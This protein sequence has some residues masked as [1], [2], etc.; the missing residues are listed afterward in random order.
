MKLKHQPHAPSALH[1]G[2]KPWYTL[3][4]STVSPQNQPQWKH[5]SNPII[6]TFTEYNAIIN[7]SVKRKIK[8]IKQTCS[9]SYS[10]E[11]TN[12]YILITFN[13]WVIR[14]TMSSMITYMRNKLNI[15]HRYSQKEWRGGGIYC[16][17]KI[18]CLVYI[19]QSI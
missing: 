18:P 13:R 16:T 1:T 3:N 10:S 5:S 12:I 14:W 6:P 8:C 7:Q 15:K 9:T 11:C 19:L 2:K 4:R 17:T